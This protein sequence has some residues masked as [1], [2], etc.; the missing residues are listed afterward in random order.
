MEFSKDS[1][2]INILNSSLTLLTNNNT[3]EIIINNYNNLNWSELEFNN[4]T[5]SISNNDGII[6]MID[7][8]ILEIL[9]DNDNALIIYN[10]SNIIKYCN[11]ESLE[12]INSYKFLNKKKNLSNKLD[13]LFDY[14]ILF[15]IN[16]TNE[17]SS[18]PDNWNTVKKK[19]T[20]YKKI[21]YVDKI[22]DIEYVTT[23][24][25]KNKEDDTFENFK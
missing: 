13:N 22:N 23:L 11:N 25:K 24:I 10:M 4:F 15:N 12:N 18:L 6:E 9:D 17:L 19:Y 8:E 14:N 7:D 16:E 1:D 2:I 5:S 3:F 20:I 21:K